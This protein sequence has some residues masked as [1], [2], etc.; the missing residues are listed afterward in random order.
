M[1]AAPWEA[2]LLAD[3]LHGVQVEELRLEAL[4]RRVDQERASVVLDRDDRAAIEQDALGLRL[5]VTRKALRHLE[6]GGFLEGASVKV[7]QSTIDPILLEV[8][9]NQM[10]AIADEMELPLIK[11]AA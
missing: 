9:T 8:L 10:D 2:G 3:V 7:T 11:S 4:H 6:L 1:A 5:D